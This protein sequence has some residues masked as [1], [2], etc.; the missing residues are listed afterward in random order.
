MSIRD[1][2]I[3][4]N[5]RGI[6]STVEQPLS[7]LEHRSQVFRKG[8][9][10]WQAGDVQENILIVKR[11]FLSAYR[12]LADG[13]RQAIEVFLPGDIAGIGEIGFTR[14]LTDMVSIG[15]TE[16][17]IVSRACLSDVFSQSLSLCRQF[18][19]SATQRQAMLVERL[20]DLGR[21]SARQRMAHFLMECHARMFAYSSERS[22][23]IN[24][25]PLPVLP[26]SQV[27]LSDIL[28]LSAVHVNRT[29][30]DLRGE[31][32]VA[33]CSG[34]LHVCE[35]EKLRRVADFCS[36]YLEQDNNLFFRPVALSAV[37]ETPARHQVQGL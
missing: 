19:L 16:V 6:E 11:G 2:S 27:F 30:K 37:K 5:D 29:L 10:I 36:A 32:L 17:G 31:G 33:T 21:R 15:E 8:A 34:G 18:L 20:V 12:Q 7:S 9:T 22:A 13:R 24:A 23:M 28:G 35:P 4:Q 25:Q 14:R 3:A 26:F 1:S